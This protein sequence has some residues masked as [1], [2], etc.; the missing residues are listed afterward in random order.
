M[1]CS[2]F[3]ISVSGACAIDGH[4]RYNHYDNALILTAAIYCLQA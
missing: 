2:L 3:W 4:V 1:N